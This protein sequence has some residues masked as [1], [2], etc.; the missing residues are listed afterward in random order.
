MV[1]SRNNGTYKSLYSRCS[2]PR[3]L[4]LF[5]LEVFLDENGLF[6]VNLNSLYNFNEKLLVSELS[7][8]M[9]ITIEHFCHAI[10]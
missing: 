5:C 7:I 6:G 8:Y 10:V 4:G 2:A 9:Y 1:C 3:G